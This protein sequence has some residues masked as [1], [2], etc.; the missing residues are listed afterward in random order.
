[1]NKLLFNITVRL[2]SIL[3]DHFFRK[4]LKAKYYHNIANGI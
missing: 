1:M 2:E 3:M 4:L